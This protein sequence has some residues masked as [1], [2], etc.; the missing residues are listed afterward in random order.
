MVLK[1]P[2]DLLQ[3]VLKFIMNALEP[4]LQKKKNPMKIQ[5]YFLFQE[6]D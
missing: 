1:P 2:N 3:V 4:W 6:L 5:M